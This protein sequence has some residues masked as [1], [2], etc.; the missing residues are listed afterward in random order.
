[1]GGGGR[2]LRLGLWRAFEVSDF[3]GCFGGP[4]IHVRP[5]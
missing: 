4:A 2:G 1:V 3:P 5:R